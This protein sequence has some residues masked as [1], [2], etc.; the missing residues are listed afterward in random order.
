MTTEY[1][2]KDVMGRPC[3]CPQAMRPLGRLEGISMGQGMVRLHTT[4]GCPTHDTC[5]GFT[6]AYRKDWGPE[7]C[8]LQCPIHGSKDCS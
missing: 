7:G 6:A 1:P 4:K 5:R 2:G 8:W 3:T